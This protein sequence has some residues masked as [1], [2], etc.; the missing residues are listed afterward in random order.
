MFEKKNLTIH[1]DVCDARNIKAE[2]YEGFEKIKINADFLLVN[3]KSKP[4]LHRL[5]LTC[6]VDNVLEL[7]DGEEIHL[8]TINGSYEIG[9]T[10]SV[11]PYT[12]LTVNG[13]LTILPGAETIVEQ[14]IKIC[15]NGSVRCPQSIASALNCATING[16]SV[17][18]PDD[19]ILLSA[20]FTPDKYFPLRAKENSRYYVHKRVILDNNEVDLDTLVSKK[21]H[22]VTKNLIVSEPLLEKAIPLF[23]ETVDFTVVPAGYRIICEDVTLDRALLTKFG[24]K[25]F[26]DGNLTLK[27]DSAA[28]C[29][30]IEGLIVKGTVFLN[31]NDLEAFRS[32]PA[33]YDAMEIITGR[34]F[35]NHLQVKL[36]NAVLEKSPDGI[37]VKNV[38]QV[39]L[40]AD[41]ACD[42]IL[43]KLTF[44]NCTSILCT[45]EQEGSV[46]A[47]CTNCVQVGS[48]ENDDS[49]E[50]SKALSHTQVINAD[51]YVL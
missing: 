41:I 39:T 9:P 15:I 20:Q 5:P 29:R 4:V 36:D 28:L 22:F 30:E 40:A 47:V 14:Y 3:E 6:N 34:V 27:D 13:N 44:Q 50:L 17:T 49:A 24:P 31:Q 46:S 42:D 8:Q 48:A 32:I 12:V 10:T 37:L 16:V 7:P 23:D 1:C 26:I 18:Y 33:E 2:H 45:P 11:Q 25:L 51:S 35:E 21:V 38:V 19:C 43:E